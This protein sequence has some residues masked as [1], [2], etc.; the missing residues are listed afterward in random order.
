MAGSR[1]GRALNAVKPLFPLLVA[2]PQVV[3]H[4]FVD[5]RFQRLR[6]RLR[7]VPEMRSAA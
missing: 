7:W 6:E 3:L 1:E 2:W 4:Q 5:L